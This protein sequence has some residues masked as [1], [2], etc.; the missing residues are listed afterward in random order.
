[1]RNTL[2]RGTLNPAPGCGLRPHR[3]TG[4]AQLGNA[5]STGD[6]HSNL[7]P[8]CSMR[9]VVKPAPGVGLQVTE[10]PV[11]VI[12]ARDVLIRVHHAGVCGTDLHI[13]EW[14]AWAAGRL[15]PPVTVGHEFA[16][17]VVELGPEA[18]DEAILAPGDLVTAE[19][20]IVCGDCH[21]C[22]TGDA[23]LCIRTQIIGVDRDGAFA[24]YIS[25]PA[26]NVMKLE[27]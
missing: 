23:H 25:M 3:P 13:W 22:R 2:C 1:M 27:G 18:R 19:G 7:L 17:E 16:G 6:I 8:G 14:D 26:S 20:H 24:D 5:W 9:A 15:R 10:V 12:G 4:S 21:P 11:P